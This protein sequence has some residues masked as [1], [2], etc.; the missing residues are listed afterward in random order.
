M[1]CELWGIGY[2]GSAGR[3]GIHILCGR[4]KRSGRRDLNPRSLAPK[5]SALAPRL[6]PVVKAVYR[7]RLWS[8]IENV[9]EIRRLHPLQAEI[10]ISPAACTFVPGH[11]QFQPGL[12]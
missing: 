8:S 11:T 6:R 1:K 10:N 2:L 7:K 5:A 9:E 3:G 4:E 12:S